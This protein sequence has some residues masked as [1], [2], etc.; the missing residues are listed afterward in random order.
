MC[1]TIESLWI[2]VRKLNLALSSVIILCLIYLSSMETLLRIFPTTVLFDNDFHANLI[3]TALY[4]D[5]LRS[6]IP[7]VAGL[8][9]SASYVDEIK[10]GYARYVY[11]RTGRTAYIVSHIVVCFLCGA[12]V[13]LV[14]ISSAWGV[15]ALL[16]KRLESNISVLS[17]T[18]FEIFKLGILLCLTG[19]LWAVVG[20]MMST[21][22][23]S[24]YIAY[25]SPFIIYYLLIILCKRYIPKA[26]IISPQSWAES[27]MWPFEW[28]GSVILI[29]GLVLL[30]SALFAFRAERRLRQL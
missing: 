27:S 21:F 4:S 25:A 9:F 3:Y 1:K 11:I 19:G 30:S 16:F 23:E 15:A 28:F 17:N 22:M 10:S 29:V 26:Y 2:E 14:G 13:I 6:F 8:S 24:K 12:F 18:R 7:I 20:M 5:I